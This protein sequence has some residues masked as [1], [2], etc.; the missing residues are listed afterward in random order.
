[1]R[2]VTPVTRDQ[3]LLL[4]REAIVDDFAHRDD[5]G[6][7]LYDD[8]R[9]GRLLAREPALARGVVDLLDTK[10]GASREDLLAALVAIVTIVRRIGGYMTH[11][12]QQELFGAMAL[13]EAASHEGSP[14]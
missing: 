13:I 4:A 10:Q 7:P 6:A 8:A 5:S 9:I 3:L 11:E 2:V 12:D 14:R 1:M